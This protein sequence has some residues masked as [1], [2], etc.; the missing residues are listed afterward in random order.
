MS[1]KV[2]LKLLR[3]KF[4]QS[5]QEEKAQQV[6]REY[7]ALSG[8]ISTDDIKSDV[9]EEMEDVKDVEKN[10]KIVKKVSKKSK[11]KVKKKSKFES[12][13]ELV[14]IKGIGKETVED[15]KSIYNNLDNLIDKLNSGDKIPLRNDIVIKLRKELI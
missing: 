7:W 3:R 8:L 14:K 5:G 9:Q 4:I 1:K 2:E 13:E 12:L 10:V 11:N 6:L 15:I